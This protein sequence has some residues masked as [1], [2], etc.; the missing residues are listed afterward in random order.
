M[1]ELTLNAELRTDQ[2]KGASRRLRHAD[3]L[4]AV[5]YGANKKAASITLAQKDILKAQ[6]EESFYT[7]ILNL[8]IDGKT[9]KVLVKDMQRHPFKPVVMHID[10][11]RINAS[12]KLHKAVPIHFI[13]EATSGAVKA[14]GTVNHLLNEAVVV[15]LPKNL[16]EAFEVD[17]AAMEVGQTLHLSDLILPKG[18]ELAEL[19]KGADHD[20]AIVTITAA[21]GNSGDGEASEEVAADDSAE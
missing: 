19:A 18:V 11:L 12:Q 14:G 6:E 21:K 4:P 8:D 13:N 10:F 2:G 17:I 16:P 9:E 7:Q 5:I 15:C 20:Q 1:S 3:R